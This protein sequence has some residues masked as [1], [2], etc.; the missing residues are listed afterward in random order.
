MTAKEAR[1]IIRNNYGYEGAARIYE[2]IQIKIKEAALENRFGCEVKC[3]NSSFFVDS[4]GEKHQIA[5]YSKIEAAMS[6]LREDGFNC[7]ISQSGENWKVEV[8]W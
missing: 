3:P 8:E 2:Y 6:L 5:N 7:R 1:E 4:K